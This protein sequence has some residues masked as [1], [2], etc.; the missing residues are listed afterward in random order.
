M[1]AFQT[2]PPL[3]RA[4]LPIA[5]LAKCCGGERGSLRTPRSGLT[6]YNVSI[7]IIR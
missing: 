4:V 3:K 7:A 6:W 2:M 5:W 1:S